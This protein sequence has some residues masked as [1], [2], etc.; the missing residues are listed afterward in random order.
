MG[1]QMKFVDTD[2]EVVAFKLLD[3]RLEMWGN[4]IRYLHARGKPSTRFPRGR[5][6]ETERD[7]HHQVNR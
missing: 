1:N 2:I 6:V 5:P 4:G 7:A 3:K